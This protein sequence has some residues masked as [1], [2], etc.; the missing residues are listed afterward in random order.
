MLGRL[1]SRRSITRPLGIIQAVSRQSSLRA[2]SS[3]IAHSNSKVK[4]IKTK[5]EIAKEKL[6]EQLKSENR[7]IRWGAIVRTEKFTKGMTKYLIGAYVFFLIY[8]LY[9]MK[10]M[11]AK[12]KELEKLE[13]K[14]L[15]GKANEFETLRIKE[16]R[17]KL[18]TRDERKLAQYREM[19]WDENQDSSQ[20][21][22]V[23]LANNNENNTNKKILP[24]RDTTDFYDFKASEY[25]EGVN[26]EEKAIFMG[27]RRKWL[28]K[29]CKGDVLEAACGTGRN[30]KYAD[31]S[32]INSITFLD[33]SEKMMEL[34]H[35]K[36]RKEFPNFKKAAFVVGRA[37]NL[38]NLAAGGEGQGV[39]PDTKVKYDTIVEAFGLCSLEDP[40]KSLQNFERLLKP[41]GR[42]VL[43]EHGRGNY[44][45]INKILDDRAEKRLETWGC[46]WNLDLGEILDDSGL[47][48]VEENRTHFG[49]TWC[50]IAKRK[51]D[52]KKNEEVGFVEKYVS[53]SIKNKIEAYANVE[54]SSKKLNDAETTSDK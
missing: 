37:E 32:K 46:R 4:R 54:G 19:T 33:A 6:E 35:D 21:D 22:H 34:T 27:R 18:R 50:V 20:Y 44:D 43:L 26:F 28:M 48:V 41:G 52:L 16:L 5:E 25:D 1:L 9:F 11:Y 42:I 45:F 14:Q 39:N 40:V 38:V 47:E 53:S 10:K 29:Y 23:T 17:G 49:T 24:A 30:L 3:Y 31:L 36:F 13:A 8:G 2:R 12:E 15:E 51:G 7:F